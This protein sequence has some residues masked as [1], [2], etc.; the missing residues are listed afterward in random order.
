MK[1]DKAGDKRSIEVYNDLNSTASKSA[2]ER[3]RSHRRKG[4]DPE[5]I[6]RFRSMYTHGATN[7]RIRLDLGLSDRVIKRM[8]QELNLPK[9][10]IDAGED[11]AR[12]EGWVTF[13]FDISE[14]LYRR[15]NAHAST[16]YRSRAHYV[17]ALIERDLGKS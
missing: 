8:R 6:R 17:R 9:R 16:R 4:D 2:P 3:K 10:R 13:S 1:D 15:M 7:K 5:T 14:N 11:G 12:T